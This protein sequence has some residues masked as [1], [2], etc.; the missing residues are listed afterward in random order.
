MISS[1][2]ICRRTK[3]YYCVAV[4]VFRERANKHIFVVSVKYIVI[5]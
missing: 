5:K 1:V 2:F 4:L 3:L